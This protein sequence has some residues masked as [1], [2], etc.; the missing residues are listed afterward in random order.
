MAERMHSPEG[1][2]RYCSLFTPRQRKDSKGNAQGDPKYQITL[3]FNDPAVLKAMKKAAQEVGEEKFGK[4][5]MDLVLKGKANWPFGKNTDR[6]DDDGNRHPGFEDDDG[7]YVGFK[8]KDKPGVVD[9]DA[10]PIM[11]KSEVYDGMLARVSCRPFAY[12][13]ESKGVAFA[14]I[15][16]QKL[17]DGERLS[18]DPSAEDD[19]KPAKGKKAAGKKS[20]RVDDDDP[21]A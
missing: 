20:K 21:M 18:G 11:D 8:T 17:D 16:V 2:A 7:L 19:F 10:E 1:V 3:I 5:F 4:K 15:N 14:L 13:N 9:A 6:E 12:D